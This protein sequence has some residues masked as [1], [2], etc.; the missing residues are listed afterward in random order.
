MLSC[1]SD[2]EG[3]QN[4]AQYLIKDLQTILF[5]NLLFFPKINHL[6]GKKIGKAANYNKILTCRNNEDAMLT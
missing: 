3:F 1:S 4:A 2:D 6:L 5:S